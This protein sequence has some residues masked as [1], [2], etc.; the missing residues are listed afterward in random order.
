MGFLGGV[1]PQSGDMQTMYHRPHEGYSFGPMTV[2]HGDCP[3]RSP[4]PD[5]RVQKA[6]PI[7][8]H[9]HSC[10]HKETAMKVRIGEPSPHALE[11]ATKRR[12]Q[13]KSYDKLCLREMA[14]GDAT[15]LA[16][17]EIQNYR[18]CRSMAPHNPW[19]AQRHSPDGPKFV[20]IHPDFK[21]PARTEIRQN[22]DTAAAQEDKSASQERSQSI[23]QTVSG[24][25]GATG[26]QQGQEEQQAT[27]QIPPSANVATR[28]RASSRFGL[29]GPK[30]RT[31]RTPRDKTPLTA[32][33]ESEKAIRS[34]NHRMHQGFYRNA[35]GTLGSSK[36]KEHQ[37][38]RSNTQYPEYKDENIRVDGTLSVGIRKDPLDVQNISLTS[39]CI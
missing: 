22:N 23:L 11:Q 36:Q 37:K 34:A 30:Y 27:V 14:F 17:R 15:N 31:D 8:Y 19:D 12:M 38:Y 33:Q 5:G 18:R 13:Q 29:D 7:E 26:E 16:A 2:H 6:E 35:G 9:N 4:S 10:P 21:P 32:Q 1:R 24:F 25:F 39:I 3:P 28:G 20:Q